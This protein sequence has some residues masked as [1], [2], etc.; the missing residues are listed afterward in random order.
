MP[1]LPVVRACSGR[2]RTTK[3]H[4]RLQQLA[5]V[6]TGRAGDRVPEFFG[7]NLQHV[8]WVK[9]SR[10]LQSF[11]RLAAASLSPAHLVHRDQLWT[12]ILLAPGFQPSFSAWWAHRELRHGEPAHVPC[13][14]PPADMA[15]LIQLGLDFE[16]NQLEKA[17][18]ESA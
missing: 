1:G 10:R 4:K 7:S 15:R 2:G 16:L 3:P 14:P 11:V 12:S 6:K 8:Q 17:F 5:P 9:Q 13:V 18:P